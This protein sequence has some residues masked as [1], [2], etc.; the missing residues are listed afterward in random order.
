MYSCGFGFQYTWAGNC[1]TFRYFKWPKTQSQAQSI[2]SKWYSNLAFNPKIRLHF[3][4]NSTTAGLVYLRDC[5]KINSSVFL[6]TVVI[7]YILLLYRLSWWRHR[8]K[9]WV[10]QTPIDIVMNVVVAVRSANV[11]L[12]S[13]LLLSKWST[14]K[15]RN[16]KMN[17]FLFC[18]C[19]CFCCYCFF[20]GITSR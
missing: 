5:S 12:P 19:F 13:I 10:Y 15:S 11:L 20:H 1:V 4:L 14:R 18:F 16:G 2:N 3:L 8:F 17:A 6:L 9:W 7:C